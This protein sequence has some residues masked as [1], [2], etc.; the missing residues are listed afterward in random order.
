MAKLLVLLADGFEEIEAVTIIDVCRRGGID[1]TS[2]S[3]S[4]SLS[5]KGANGI[6]IM[7]DSLLS[8]IDTKGFDMVVL[9]GGW[10]GTKELATNEMVQSVLKEYKKEDKYIGAICAAPF[11]LKS[12]DVLNSNYT[13]YPSVEESIKQEGYHKDDDIVI[14]SKVITSRGPATAMKFGLEIISILV[15]EETSLAISGGLL[16]T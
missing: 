16:Y 14:D 13:C 10:G 5:V 1:V 2:A 15:D 7:A 3:V 6:T 8:S 12:A 4:D 11:A 9:P